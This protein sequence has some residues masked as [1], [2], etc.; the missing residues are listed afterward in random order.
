MTDPVVR[1]QAPAKI[2]LTLHVA[3]PAM[4]GLHPLRSLVVFAPDAADRLEARPAPGLSLRIDG[5]FAPGL[6]SG[7]TN[8]VLR[9]ARVLADAAGGRHGAQ[10]RL[11]KALPVASGIGGGSA[12]AAAT[13][14]ALSRLWGLDWPQERLEGLAATLGADVPA[15]VSGGPAW[16]GG[17]G[18]ELDPVTGLAPLDAVLVNPGVPCAT[19]AVYAAFD[20]AAGNGRLDHEPALPVAGDG[21]AL[22]DWLTGQRNDL[23]AT[24][25][26]LVPQIGMAL[27]ALEATPGIG[28]ARMSGSGATCFGLVLPDVPVDLAALQARLAPGSWVCRTRLATAAP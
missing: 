22:L 5:P 4:S 6:D 13:L 14:R 3:A 25:T 16:M 21:S 24:A 28:L 10:L 18:A 9:A 1:E 27:E 20:R 17:F 7:D 2:N 26:A 19:G 23:Q 12:D 8:L 15:C 11:H